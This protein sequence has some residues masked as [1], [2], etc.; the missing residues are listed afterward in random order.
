MTGH[1]YSSSVTFGTTTLTN[2]GGS[3]FVFKLGN[4]ITSIDDLFFDSTLKIFPN[5]F[6][7]STTILVKE[8]LKDATLIVYNSFGQT[9][10]EIKNIS[11]QTCTLSRENLANGLYLFVQ[12]KEG[13]KTHTQK[14][15][16]F[17]K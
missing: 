15:V 8:Y 3:I 7:S 11:G 2:T 16:I 5:P 17:D 1:F 4:E 12:L 13:N 14:L 6:S 10:K 9:V